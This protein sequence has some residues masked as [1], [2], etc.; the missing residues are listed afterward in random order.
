MAMEGHFCH[1]NPNLVSAYFD[2]FLN[3]KVAHISVVMAER[4]AMA[5]DTLEAVRMVVAVAGKV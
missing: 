4:M 3:L 1:R 2:P 5:T